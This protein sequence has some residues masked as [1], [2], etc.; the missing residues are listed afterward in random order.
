MFKKSLLF[1]AAA[2]AITLA[3]L[4]L[5]VFAGC[6]NPSSGETTYVERPVTGFQ[7]PEGTVQAGSP[8][9][10]EG[11]L[12]DIDAES[13]GVKTNQVTH[14]AYR[15]T[16]LDRNLIIPA[17][18]TV[19]VVSDLT[20][21]NDLDFQLVVDDGA[22]LIVIPEG[23]LAIGT[24]YLL[25]RGRVEA[26]G[27][28]N[29]GIE[30]RRIA[31]YS[32]EN[33]VIQ[34]EGRNTVIG[35]S[36]VVVH[37][38]GTLHL[39]AS[40]IL[41]PDNPPM[42][43]KFIP[44]QAWAAAGQ[45]SLIIGTDVNGNGSS[46]DTGDDFLSS[47]FTIKYLV[48]GIVPSLGR[49]YTV[50]TLGGGVLPA[51]IL[52]GTIIT[53]LGPIT[54]SD[55]PEHKL[56]IDGVLLAPN[57]TLGDIVTLIISSRSLTE[58]N[59]E[60]PA[61]AS[62]RTGMGDIDYAA[63]YGFGALG[64]DKVTL[65]KV[66]KLTIGDNGFFQ[67]DSDVIELAPGAVIELGKGASFISTSAIPR[68][69][70]PKALYLGPAAS[71]T[72]DSPQLRFSSLE[73]L[74]L[75]DSASI[76]AHNGNATFTTEPEKKLK[77]IIGK[78]VFYNVTVEPTAIVDVSF[79]DDA[80]ILP[81]ST[82]KVNQGSTLEV[83]EGAT[84]TVSGNG[85]ADGVLD[86]MTDLINDSNLATPPIQ[87]NGTIVLED[88]A[89]LRLPDPT[90]FSTPGDA[91]TVV[92]YGENGKLVLKH[93][94][95]AYL[96][97]IK[98]VGASGVYE[99]AATTGGVESSIEIT[100]H[101][102]TVRGTVTIAQSNYIQNWDTVDI[103]A[104]SKV[105]LNDG[106]SLSLVGA[107][108]GGAKIVGAGKLVA[109]HTE[110]SGGP[111]GWQVFGGT[112]LIVINPS[113]EVTTISAKK[114]DGT[115]ADANNTTYLKAFGP[116]A[117]IT[118][119]AGANNSLT[120]AVNTKIDLG[121]DIATPTKKAGEIILKNVIVT[122][123]PKTS[124]ADGGKLVLT[125]DKAIIAT[126]NAAATT[127]TASAPLDPD[128]TTEVGSTTTFTKLGVAYLTSTDNVAK[129]TVAPTNATTAPTGYLATL[130]GISTSTTGTIIGGH[131]TGNSA[132][133]DGRIS[134]ETVTAAD[135][136]P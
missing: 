116:G 25:V 17:G 5:L 120:L 94:S 105:T 16:A 96:G 52:A 56:T 114:P 134:S 77:T 1:G 23:S 24:G 79:E 78:N 15:G 125:G 136:N 7:F 48:E 35:T 74:V 113:S 121:T 99:I 26:Y 89:V 22:T 46:A 76:D 38:G 47:A 86:L 128:E 130:S 124:N 58:K 98:F 135:T 123:S 64:A 90:G 127:V 73:T 49:T 37:A 32:V 107:A 67:S 66:T 83:A 131:D 31:D 9:V 14:I 75:K 118:Q 34:V 92:G 4:A 129:S 61:V 71:V 117:T 100:T 119:K 133:Q 57:A 30:A 50:H 59:P 82:L 60:S 68:F 28:L 51:R 11:L 42:P 44:A 112:D 91:N 45:G 62:A 19:Y 55:D 70:S 110:I 13:D 109:G 106:L 132:D 103:T 87:I 80:S 72:I 126:G 122:G 85:S 43:N 54:D 33:G 95:E 65:A 2:R 18:K 104:N 88:N 97:A 115:P 84:L 3:L 108:T 27:S 101:K 12:N 81:G 111:S 21:A 8:A 40:D 10:L 93:G 41:T 69:D 6:S 53:A 102:N 39:A 36:H 63:D 20:G 29:V